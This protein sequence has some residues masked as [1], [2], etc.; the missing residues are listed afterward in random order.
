MGATSRPRLGLGGDLEKEVI[1][2]VERCGVVSTQPASRS[3]PVGKSTC[4]LVSRS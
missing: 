3:T 1:L 4:E 2:G